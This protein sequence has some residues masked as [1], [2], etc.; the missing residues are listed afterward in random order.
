MSPGAVRPRPGRASAPAPGRPRPSGKVQLRRPGSGCRRGAAWG[1]RTASTIAEV[2][3]TAPRRPQNSSA[4]SAAEAR[5]TSP[6]AVTT[7]KERTLSQAQPYWR[8]SQPIPPPSVRPPTP[9]C[10]TLPAV[11]ASPYCWVAASRAPSNAP[12]FCNPLDKGDDRRATVDHR[13]PDPAHPRRT[14]RS[15]RTQNLLYFHIPTLPPSARRSTKR[16]DQSSTGNSS[17]PSSGAH[18]DGAV[19]HGLLD[20]LLHLS[21]RHGHVLADQGAPEAVPGRLQNV[22]I[23]WTFAMGRVA[24]LR[25]RAAIGHRGGPAGQ[26]QEQATAEPVI[27]DPAPTSVSVSVALR[28]PQTGQFPVGV[29]RRSSMAQ[30]LQPG[31]AELAGTASVRPS[32]LGDVRPGR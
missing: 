22:G 27:S 1:T 12:P 8:A 9:V 10:E 18:R 24:S 15:P 20:V 7:S 28:Q 16:T 4:F 19:R 32:V 13:I 30:S 14:R 2:A 17:R 29:E 6:A 31:Q 11:V 5:T 25:C 23:R 3:A 26:E 21:R